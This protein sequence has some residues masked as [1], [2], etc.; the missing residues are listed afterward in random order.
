M[1]QGAIVSIVRFGKKRVVLSGIGSHSTLI[2]DNKKLLEKRGWKEDAPNQ[3]V[4][5]YE[6]DFTQNKWG[7]FT[8][9]AGDPKKGDE[10]I[11]KAEFKRVSGSASALIKHIQRIGRIDDALVKLL[12]APAWEAYSEATA[13]AWK[14]Y[15]EATA[16]ALEAYNEATATALGAYSEATATA[17]EAY[18][19][20]TATALEAYNEATAPAWE[21]YS[22]A[23]APAWEAYNEATATALE[24]L[25]RGKG[26]GI[27]SLQRGNGY[28]I[29]SLQRGNGYGIHK[30]FPQSQ[31][32]DN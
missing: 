14:A 27:G 15:N 24:S 18:N 4:V 10:K 1:C 13:P 17:L 6:S 29:G 12:T 26:Y 16:P 9:E 2:A 32:Q 7:K 28:G 25:Q 31:K 21:A 8:H 3:S 20:A 11:V 22:E 30:N 23:T 19:E 5:S